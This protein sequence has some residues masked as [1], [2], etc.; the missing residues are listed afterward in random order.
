MKSSLGNFKP[1]PKQRPTELSDA[2]REQLKQT[3]RM[4]TIEAKHL[5]YVLAGTDTPTNQCVVADMVEVAAGDVSVCGAKSMLIEELRQF[6]TETGATKDIRCASVAVLEMTDSPV[7]VHASTIEHYIVLSGKGKLILGTGD[8][9][10]I[11]AVQQG[12]VILLPPGQPHGIVSDDSSV[13]I[14]ALLTFTPG[15][16]PKEEPEFRDEEVIYLRAS[17]RLRAIG[18]INRR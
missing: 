7:H 8:E 4:R 13:P 16:A 17:D 15:L 2:E 9:E 1:V 3:L 10:R 11:V 14:R 5:G 12:S 6:T 18:E